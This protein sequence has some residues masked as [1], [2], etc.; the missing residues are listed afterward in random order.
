V[1]V[2]LAHSEGD[3]ELTEFK[4]L[5]ACQLVMRQK[6]YDASAGRHYDVRLMKVVVLN[7]SPKPKVVYERAI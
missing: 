7:G 2:S 4:L 5:E 1:P 6:A 3:G